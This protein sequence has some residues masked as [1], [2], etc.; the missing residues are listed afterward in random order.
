MSDLPLFDPF[1][2]LEEIRSKNREATPAGALAK[3]LAELSQPAEGVNLHS[4]QSLMPN[5]STLAILAGGSPHAAPPHARE[6]EE[7]EKENIIISYTYAR[8]GVS[9][10]GS[11]AATA[12]PPARVARSARDDLSHSDKTNLSEIRP[13]RV[14]Q[15]GLV[16]WRLGLS[17]VSA[18]CPPCP[19]Y[20]GDEWASVLR[21]ALRFL[22]TFGVQAEALGWTTARLFGVHPEIGIGRVD[23]CGPLVLPIGGPV[24][25]I[26]ATEIAL[27]HLTH[28]EKPGQ[29]TGVPVWEFGR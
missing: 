21:R 28:R 11:E 26:T 6:E 19:G 29:P 5:S 8:E 27:G 17:R 20:R 13:A 15:D 25:A 4:D 9:A 23:H 2:A 14:F 12:A 1:K 18:E 22:D 3:T 16:H 24:R 10:G 7:E